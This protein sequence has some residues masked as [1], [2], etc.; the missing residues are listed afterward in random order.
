MKEKLRA[1]DVGRLSAVFLVGVLLTVALFYFVLGC[2]SDWLVIAGLF[3]DAGGAGLLAAP[4]LGWFKSYTYSGQVKEALDELSGTGDMWVRVEADWYN[5][6]LEE[7]EGVLGTEE[8][9]N[10]AEFRI[11]RNRNSNLLWYMPDPRNDD[12]DN[13]A[14]NLFNVFTPF[15]DTVEEEE[16]KVRRY[17]AYVFIAGIGFQITGLLVDKILFSSIFC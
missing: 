2:G 17:G 12:V 11:E 5:A 7:M 3:V 15:R 13:K 4:D 14:I 6:F 1:N 8:I 9:P 10:S 16:T